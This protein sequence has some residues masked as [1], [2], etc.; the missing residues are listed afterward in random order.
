MHTDVDSTTTTKMLN[1]SLA[2][3]NILVLETTSLKLRSTIGKATRLKRRALDK[4]CALS[5]FSGVV[6]AGM[7]G[8]NAGQTKKADGNSRSN[9][10]HCYCM[11]DWEGQKKR[12]V[13]C[14]DQ[15]D[16]D[17]SKTLGVLAAFIL[18]E[19]HPQFP[20]GTSFQPIPNSLICL[21]DPKYP[22]IPLRL[23]KNPSSNPQI[24]TVTLHINQVHSPMRPNTRPTADTKLDPEAP[25]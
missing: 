17:P 9:V 5:S 1:G 23:T 2:T 13:D 14:K 22:I 24:T 18:R 25:V 16:D 7:S 15:D 20:L 4:G 11:K 8:H 12:S 10:N 21:V 6:V 19:D 3:G